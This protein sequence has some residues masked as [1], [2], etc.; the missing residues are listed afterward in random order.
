MIKN[1]KN[2][3]NEGLLKGKSVDDVKKTMIGLSYE[4]IFYQVM[5]SMLNSTLEELNELKSVNYDNVFVI[6]IV[7]NDWDYVLE[8]V[9]ICEIDAEKIK[10]TIY[11]TIST[12]Y[13]N[14][15][16]D[17]NITEYE[18][19]HNKM[20]IIVDKIDKNTIF[21][22]I[23]KLVFND[24]SPLNIYYKKDGVVTTLSYGDNILSCLD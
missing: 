12:Y 14:Y 21:E 24:D 18:K 13:K 1:Y 2:F 20:S 5:K 6:E 8:S 23:G 19:E 16:Y 15:F 3:I 17:D 10:K 9:G 4:Q 11:N 22:D 7:A